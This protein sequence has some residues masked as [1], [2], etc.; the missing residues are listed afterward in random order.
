MN[1]SLRA[2][3]AVGCVRKAFGRLSHELERVPEID[4]LGIDQAL[5]HQ[6]LDRLTELLRTAQRIAHRKHT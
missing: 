3:E 5:A 4:Q 2:A 1:A 6:L